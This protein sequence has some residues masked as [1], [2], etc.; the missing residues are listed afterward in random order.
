MK[1]LSSKG[2]GWVEGEEPGARG[3]LASLDSAWLTCFR[4]SDNFTIHRPRPIPER[5]LSIS[6]CGGP[7]PPTS[8]SPL[9]ADSGRQKLGQVSSRVCSIAE[10]RAHVTEVKIIKGKG[11]S[12]VREREGW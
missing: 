9:G 1:G 6:N 11:R 7:Q 8:L 4:P 12:L 2:R 5:H 3:L 10:R